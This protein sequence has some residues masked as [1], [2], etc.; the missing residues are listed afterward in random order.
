MKHSLIQRLFPGGTADQVWRLW[1]R[2]DRLF[3]YLDRVPKTFSHL[4]A[5]RRNLF[6]GIDARERQ[7]LRIVD[8]AFAG[9]AP[10][11]AELN[12]LVVGSVLLYAMEP[13]DFAQLERAALNGYV[14]GLEEIGQKYEQHYI[15]A[16]FAASAAL[17]YV[18]YILVRMPI[19]LDER[20]CAWAEGVLGHSIEDFIDR[21]VEVRQYLFDLTPEVL[22]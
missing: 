17:R 9:T 3:D 2:R 19:L 12:A 14:E 7:E 10:I 8:W 13:S 5:N 21:C 18:A 15:R 6:L 20:L 22:P 16:S 1:A 4:D 11:G